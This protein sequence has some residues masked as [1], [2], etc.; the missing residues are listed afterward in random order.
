MGPWKEVYARQ[1]D[2]QH[3][4][5]TELRGIQDPDAAI[6]VPMILDNIEGA[7]SPPVPVG[8]L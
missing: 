7:E 6:S 5:V 8:S 3:D 4:I 1:S 2:A